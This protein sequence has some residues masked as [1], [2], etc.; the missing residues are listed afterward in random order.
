MIRKGTIS[1]LFLCLIIITGTAWAEQGLQVDGRFADWPGQMSLNDRQYDGLI[2]EDF[3]KLSWGTTENQQS[4]YFMLEKYPITVDTTGTFVCFMFFDINANGSYQ[5]DIDKF[6]QINYTPQEN[7]GTVEIKLF[8]INGRYLASYRGTWGE[9]LSEGGNRLEFAIPMKDLDIYPA[10]PVNFYLTGIGGDNDR[11]PDKGD[12]MWKPFPVMVR[13]KLT[14]GVAVILWFIITVFFY[15]HRIW[16]FYYV[17]GAVGFTF[18]LIL[19]LRGSFVEYQLEHQTAV[20]LYHLLNIFN[21][22]AVVFDRAFGTLLVMVEVDQSW[23]TVN[24]D[25][26]SSSLLE[27]TILLGLL[28][29]YPAYTRPKKLLLSLVAVTSVYLINILRLIII[30]LSIHFWGR[31]MIF[32]AHTI[33]GRF[34]FFI[35]IVALYWEILTKPSLKKIREN[36][37]DDRSSYRKGT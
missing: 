26:E 20:I 7:V 6:I 9:G 27:M 33:L 30:V 12:I 23:T 1:L 15:R 34:V 24:I 8:V 37:E 16:V 21:V 3:K 11:L 29:F 36:I 28:L 32:I 17:W 5:D 35:L 18:L 2:N 4:L 13:D 31:N 22:K 10:Q 14:I 19:L 25:I